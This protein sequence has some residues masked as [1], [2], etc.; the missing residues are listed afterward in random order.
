M[1]FEEYSN[2]FPLRV[3]QIQGKEG[4]GCDIL[5]FSS[6][7]LRDDFKS[8]KNRNISS[9]S[10]FIEVKGR[11]NINAE[12]ELRGNEKNCAYKH[13]EKYYI[14]R[15]SK[16]NDGEYLLGIL[17]TLCQCKRLLNNQFMFTLI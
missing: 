6:Q 17:K 10:R 14:Y 7:Q 8:N 15:L 2:R 9:V 12:I 3:G 5:S 11:K 13:S 4:F 1:E 16:T